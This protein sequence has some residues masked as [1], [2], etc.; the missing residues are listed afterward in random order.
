M[1]HHR[2]QHSLSRSLSD[3]A[4]V[5]TDLEE[6]RISSIV[7]EIANMNNIQKFNQSRNADIN[8]ANNY[9]DNDGNSLPIQHPTVTVLRMN[10]LPNID[11]TIKRSSSVNR[12]QA[13][14]VTSTTSSKTIQVNLVKLSGI[15]STTNRRFRAASVGNVSVIHVHRSSIEMRPIVRKNQ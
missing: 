7:S 13:S 10:R 15:K 6:H 12:P 4:T 2:K 5:L 1:N 11:E 8:S 3:S 9:D 14:R